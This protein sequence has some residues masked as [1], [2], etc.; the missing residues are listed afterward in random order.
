MSLSYL[1]CEIDRTSDMAQHFLLS[2]AA[3]TLSLLSVM[4]MTDGEAEK[5]FRLVRWPLLNGE[6]VCPH[7]TA[8]EAYEARRRLRPN[9]AR[10]DLGR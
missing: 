4:R 8:L 3:K 7:C 1:M 5:T 6:P 10:D 2:S 9:T